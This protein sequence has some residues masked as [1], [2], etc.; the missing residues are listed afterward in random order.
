ML[1]LYPNLQPYHTE[2]LSVDDTHRIYVEEC[3]NP[4]G[5]PVLVSHGGP[6]LGCNGDYR[7]FFDPEH[8]RIILFDQ[9]GAGRSMP[10]ASLENNTSEHLVADMEAIREQYHVDKWVLFGGSWGATLSLL[11]ALQYPQRVQGLILRG[12]FLGRRKDIDWLYEKG[13]VSEFYPDFW[14]D[15]VRGLSVW[16]EGTFLEAFHEQLTCDHNEVAR[17]AAAKAW[18]QWEARLATLSP[19]LHLE[20]DFIEPATALSLARIECHYFK[21]NCFIGDDFILQH[22]DKLAEIPGVIVQGRYDMI[23]PLQQAWALHQQWPASQLNII[24]EAGHAAIEPGITDG[25]VRAT[26]EMVRMLK[27]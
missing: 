8:Y 13:G 3:G 19:N 11:Y 17:M 18:S 4:K 5:L 25:L 27:G 16:P 6:G 1:T 9:R 26:R 22:M 2:H 7:R 12:I 23:C 15:Y 14:E 24:R 21:H 20:E 10:H